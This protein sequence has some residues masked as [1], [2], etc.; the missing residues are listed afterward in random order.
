MRFFRLKV[1]THFEL[2]PRPAFLRWSLYYDTRSTNYAIHDK[3]N[4]NLESVN[5]QQV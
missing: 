5:V 1:M 4:R 3:C 2:I